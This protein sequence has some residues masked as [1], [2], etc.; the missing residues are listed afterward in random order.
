MSLESLVVKVRAAI[1]GAESLKPLKA[2]LESALA[3]D[4]A[5]KA[6]EKR[7][8]AATAELVNLTNAAAI[9]TA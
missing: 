2:E 4:G 5:A 3:A 1:E 9:A 8:D 7:R 6:A